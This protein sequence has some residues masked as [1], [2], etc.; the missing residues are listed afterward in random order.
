MPVIWYY[1]EEVELQGALQTLTREL[2]LDMVDAEMN[3]CCKGRNIP[4]GYSLWEYTGLTWKL[5]KDA[6]LP[7]ARPSAAPKVPGLF[8]GQ[9]RA[10]PSVVAARESAV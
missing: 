1:S 3:L 10:T 2:E 6:S 4:M 7:G 8:A 9:I 5:K